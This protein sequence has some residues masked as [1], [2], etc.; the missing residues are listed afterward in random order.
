MYVDN[1]F[2]MCKHVFKQ[3]FSNECKYFSYCILWIEITL[4]VRNYL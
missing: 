3:I 1:K 4:A 2:H